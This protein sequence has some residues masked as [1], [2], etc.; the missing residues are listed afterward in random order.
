M[1]EGCRRE[2]QNDAIGEGP[3]PPLLAL[4]IRDLEPKNTAA[5]R[6]GKDKETYSP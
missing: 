2:A 3:T 4:K 1:E 6:A 5:S